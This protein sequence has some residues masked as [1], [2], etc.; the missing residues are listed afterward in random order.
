MDE[1]E[2]WILWQEGAGSDPNGEGGCLM[3]L[4]CAVIFILIFLIIMLAGR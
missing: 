3:N 2:K 4:G 1:S